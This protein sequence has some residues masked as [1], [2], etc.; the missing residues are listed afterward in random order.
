MGIYHVHRGKSTFVDNFTP[1]SVSH[2]PDPQEHIKENTPRLHLLKTYKEGSSSGPCNEKVI[3][4]EDA[5]EAA[6]I[7]SI[8]S[9]RLVNVRVSTDR[10]V[11]IG[12]LWKVQESTV[13]LLPQKGIGKNILPMA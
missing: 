11:T 7:T 8:E 2:V 1:F 5:L 4:A 9:C 12:R 13:A 10:I 6:K 3:D